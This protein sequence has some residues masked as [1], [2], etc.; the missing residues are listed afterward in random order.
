MTSGMIIGVM[1]FF[2][3]F[4]GIIG[5]PVF[6][7]I[8]A[9][10]LIATMFTE[11]S[12]LSMVGQLFNG[13]NSVPLLAV[14]FFLLAGELMSSTNVTERIINFTNHL[15]GHVRSGL[16]QVNTL[17]S[18]FFAGMSGSSNADVAAE[19]KIL[20]PQ[21]KK[22]GYDPAFTSALIAA[23][24]TLSNIVPPSIMAIIY[25]ATGGVSIIGIFLGGI[26]PG[27]LIAGGLMIYCYFF[28]APPVK[29]QRSTFIEMGGAAKRAAIPLMIPFIIM[30][31]IV[32][33]WFTPTEAGMIAVVYTIVVVIPLLKRNHFKQLPRDF[34]NAGVLFS[35]PLICVAGASAFG[36]MVAYLKAPEV[37]SGFIQGFAGTDPLLILLSVVILFIIV[38]QFVDAVPAII[39]FMP[40]ISALVELGSI[41]PVHMGVVVIVTLAFG[42]ITPPYGLALLLSASL[43]KVKFKDALMKCLPMYS[44]FLLTIALIVLIPELTLWIPKMVMPQSVGCFPGADGGW[45]CP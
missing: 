11:I 1:G 19:V 26:I 43:S 20:A 39:I 15:V 17:F 18:L 22:H 30:G 24:A 12:L 27:V 38:G 25:G 34:M 9:S 40:I 5:V 31:G 36:W 8:I 6:I 23:T 33:G 7:S 3:L 37:V 21:M 13:V 2:F 14:P 4:L 35:V 45:V 41:N 44:V 28:E 10:V 42:L 29:K 16:A 32:T